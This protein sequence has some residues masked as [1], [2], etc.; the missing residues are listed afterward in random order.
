MKINVKE[1]P[2][3]DRIS[4]LIIT[5]PVHLLHSVGRRNP[6][7][8]HK[9]N[10]KNNHKTLNKVIQCLHYKPHHKHHYNITFKFK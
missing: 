8:S 10:R 3:K 1:L 6:S 2:K 7:S 4:L 9:R 5:K